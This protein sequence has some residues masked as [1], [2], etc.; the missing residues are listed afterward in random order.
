MTLIQNKDTLEVGMHGGGTGIRTLASCCRSNAC[1][2][3]VALMLH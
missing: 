3:Y 2:A 1:K